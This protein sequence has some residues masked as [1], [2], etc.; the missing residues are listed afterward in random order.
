[1]STQAPW[2]IADVNEIPPV[3]PDWPATWKSVRHHFGITA[4]GINAVTKDADNV[5]IPE[6]NESDSGQQEL[7][8]VN[9]GSVRVTLDGEQHEAGEGA[10]IAIEPEVSRKI[11]STSS[12][13]TLV[14]I[15]GTPGKAYE[16]GDWEL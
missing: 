15:G 9:R 2:Q 6:H 13:T 12:P 11:E 14:A 4:F 5:L 8:F 7:Y 10:M 16:V 1:M 3:K